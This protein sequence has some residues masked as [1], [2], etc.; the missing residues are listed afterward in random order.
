MKKI[1]GLLFI[2][3]VFS[4]CASNNT[5][6]EDLSKANDTIKELSTIPDRMGSF[7][8]EQAQ[9]KQCVQNKLV[10]K[11]YT[12]GLDCI[13]CGG[14]SDIDFNTGK[15]TYPAGMEGCTI[16]ESTDRY[17]AEIDAE[18]SCSK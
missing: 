7:E 13:E 15:R 3:V 8:E 12:D 14:R 2:L 9:Q 4:G 16:C 6:I 11:G 17:N 18:N 1:L 10:E 5:S